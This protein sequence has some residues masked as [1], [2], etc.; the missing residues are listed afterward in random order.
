[1]SD[2]T[3]AYYYKCPKCGGSETYRA[4]RLGINSRGEQA[5]V[6]TKLCKACGEVS[7]L[8]GMSDS[9]YE[10]SQKSFWQKYWWYPLWYGF[11]IFV[12]FQIYN[13]AQGLQG[14]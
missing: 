1:M 11:L 2:L 4:P 7:E 3:M 14:R 6:D 12:G 8:F 13:W 10:D 5:M 9:E